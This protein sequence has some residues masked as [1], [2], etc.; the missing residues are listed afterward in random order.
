[1]GFKHLFA[2]GE[3]KYSWRGDADTFD[4]DMPGPGHVPDHDGTKESQNWSS[5]NWA[6]DETNK[7]GRTGPAGKGAAD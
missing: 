5:F 1:M 3:D 6:G 7:W 2:K 4:T